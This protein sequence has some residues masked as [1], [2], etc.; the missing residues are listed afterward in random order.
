MR[1]G[2]L[3][4]RGGLA[5]L[6]LVVSGCAIFKPKT[7][8]PITATD[9][10]LTV[11]HYWGTSLSGP[12][13]QAAATATAPLDTALQFHVKWLGLASVPA[14][15]PP[16]LGPRTRLI[17]ARQ[18]GQPVQPTA[19][20]TVRTHCAD[21]SDAIARFDALQNQ[22]PQNQVLIR[23]VTDLLPTGATTAMIL[24]DNGDPRYPVQREIELDITRPAMVSA[25]TQGASPVEL[26]LAFTDAA[27]PPP[28]KKDNSPPQSMR[29]RVVFDAPTGPMP[30]QLLLIMPMKFAGSPCQSLAILLTI[31]KPSN[32]PESARQYAEVMKDLQTSVREAAAIAPGSFKAASE[33]SNVTSALSAMTRFPDRRQA[34]VYLAGQCNALLCRDVAMVA[35]NDTLKTLGQQIVTSTKGLDISQSE[36]LGSLLDVATMQMLAQQQADGKLSDVLTGVLLEHTGEAGRHSSSME[37]VCKNLKNQKDLGTRLIAENLIYL[38]DNSAASRIRAYDWLAAKG[39]AP[40]GY[41][42]LGPSRQRRDALEKA[43]ASP[44]P[45]N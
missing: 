5:T 22:P 36:L 18:Q 20:L 14:D 26:A 3:L 44:Q 29:E 23:D 45:T 32:T 8:S 28:D 12:Q 19:T 1:L 21:A 43:L 24:T 37:Q 40:A 39:H 13:A 27:P 4:A 34:L 33:Q 17:L 25:A 30:R 41:D 10:A 42:P 16:P 7:P 38:E 6:L 2:M 9:T 15:L 35:D 11:A 31:D